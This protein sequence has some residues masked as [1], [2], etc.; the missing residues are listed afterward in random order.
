VYWQPEIII[1]GVIYAQGL[2]MHAPDPFS[3]PNSNCTYFTDVGFT[4]GRGR[5]AWRLNGAY[6]TFQARIGLAEQDG[7]EF[8]EFSDGVVF[9]VYLDSQPI[10]QSAPVFF[11]TP[12]L[13][14]V[15]DIA[16]GPS[17]PWR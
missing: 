10:Y 5:A 9:R 6:S 8:P 16:G 13:D 2:G 11:S 15:L 4:P 14:I 17:S 1:D 12:P 3:T 7:R